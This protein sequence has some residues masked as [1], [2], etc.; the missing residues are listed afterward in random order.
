[1]FFPFLFIRLVFFQ[2]LVVAGC[3]SVMAGGLFAMMGGFFIIPTLG[4]LFCKPL[5]FASRFSVMTGGVCVVYLCH[6]L[7]LF[8]FLFVFFGRCRVHF[9]QLFLLGSR[10]LV[11]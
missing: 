3:R 5:A 1:M 4:G 7:V 6:R 10:F 9:R 8:G 2:F 11:L